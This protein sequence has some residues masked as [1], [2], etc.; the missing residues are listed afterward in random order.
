MDEDTINAMIDAAFYEQGIV[1]VFMPEEGLRAA[2]AESRVPEPSIESVFARL[3][4]PAWAGSMVLRIGNVNN[5]IMALNGEL[6]EVFY[7]TSVIDEV[8]PAA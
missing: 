8:Q 4:H 5:Y 1:S 7:V 3:R 2:L 6:G